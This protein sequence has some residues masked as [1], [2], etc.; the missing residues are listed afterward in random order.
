VSVFREDDLWRLIGQV[1][2]VKGPTMRELWRIQSIFSRSGLVSHPDPL[3]I[4]PDYPDPLFGWWTLAVH[5]AQGVP[6]VIQVTRL[7]AEESM[8]GQHLRPADT[9]HHPCQEYVQEVARQF[10]FGEREVFS[11]HLG[12]VC[13]ST[14]TTVF[15]HQTQE[16]G[17]TVDQTWIKD[18]GSEVPRMILHHNVVTCAPSSLPEWGVAR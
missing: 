8:P 4:S 17:S 1:G 9:W 12:D 18:S 3:V 14:V 7:T 6:G 13:R 5:L 2:E 16:D 10:L 11:I 15:L